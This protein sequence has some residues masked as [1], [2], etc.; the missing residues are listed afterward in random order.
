LLYTHD[1]RQKGA[2]ATPIVPNQTDAVTVA[3]GE[4]QV[5]E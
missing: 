4:V 2:F 3:D 1:Q 5:V